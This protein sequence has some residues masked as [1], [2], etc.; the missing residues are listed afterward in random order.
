MRKDKSLTQSVGTPNGASAAPNTPLGVPTHPVCA[1]IVRLR[2]LMRLPCRKVWKFASAVT[3]LIVLSA[4]AV[5]R[6]SA[7][8]SVALLAPFEGRYREVGYNAL[9][10]AR[11][12]VADAANPGIVLLPIDDG[13]TAQSA[14]D[15]ARALASDSQ[16]RAVIVLGYAATDSATQQAFGDVPVIVVGDWGAQPADDK[17]FILSN[18]TLDSHLTVPAR[19]EITDAAVLAAPLTGGDVFAL[20]QF[21]KLRSSLEGVTV[22]SSGSP[23]DAV[24]VERYQQSD[25]FAPQPGLLATLIYDATRFVWQLVG[26]TSREETR[27]R[28]TSIQYEGINGSIQFQDGYW[29]AAP[30]HDY[31]YRSDGV[32]T[33]TSGE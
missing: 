32:L 1:S 33:E 13:G 11:L 18:P 15:R 3:L 26:A 31:Q 19:V 5:V 20:D 24:F 6:S 2:I 21:P 30:I 10:A 4:C 8:V 29:V 14:S 27:Q 16:I 25:Q 23:P 28:L 9:Y 22:L 12:A 7:P 17:V